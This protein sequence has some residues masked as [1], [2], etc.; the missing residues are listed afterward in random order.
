MCGIIGAAGNLGAKEETVTKQL[1]IVDA[2]RGVDS[3]GLAIIPRNNGDVKISKQVGNPFELNEHKSF[4]KAFQGVNRAI[5]GHNRWGTMGGNTRANAHPFEFDTVVGVHN[6]TISNKWAL[7]EGHSFGVDSAAIYNH[8]DK[9]G[10]KDA[11]NKI[12]GA[13]CL[14]WWDKYSDELNLIRNKERP[15][16]TTYSADEKVLFWASESWMLDGILHRN[17]IDRGEIKMIPV[18]THITIAVGKDGSLGKPRAVHMAQ[19]F[20]VQGGGQTATSFQGTSAS[21]TTTVAEDHKPKLTIVPKEVGDSK[22][23][24]VA[25]VSAAASSSNTQPSTPPI[26]SSSTSLAGSKQVSLEI[27]S[28]CE[29]DGYGG[30]YLSCFDEDHKYATIRWYYPRNTNVDDYIGEFITADIGPRI[31]RG[32]HAAYYKVNSMSVVLI[33]PVQEAAIEELEEE[34]ELSRFAP[35]MFPDARGKMLTKEDWEKKHGTCDWCSV[36]ISPTEGHAFSSAAQCFCKDCMESD[37]VK[38][39]AHLVSVKV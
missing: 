30:A 23:V 25:P 21:K 37:D 4:D 17:G 24:W 39:Y 14:V 27:L 2:L 19:P 10:I 33:D 7:D 22:N 3:T 5:I 29:N 11:V 9:K 28:H 1:L 36:S 8:I 18:D 38:Q 32:P 16:Y 26:R 34:Q 15:L 13:Y 6:G 20:F 35:K 31:E 12:V